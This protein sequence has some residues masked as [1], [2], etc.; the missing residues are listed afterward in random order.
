MYVY[1]KMQWLLYVPAAQPVPKTKVLWSSITANTILMTYQLT[2]GFYT[3]PWDMPPRYDGSIWYCCNINPLEGK[4]FCSICVCLALR[5]M[6]DIAINWVT[7]KFPLLML[8]LQIIFINRC[9]D[10]LGPVDLVLFTLILELVNL[11]FKY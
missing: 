2:G 5:I 8:Y 7:M 3:G 9:I 4:W 6:D 1:L 11:N 10:R